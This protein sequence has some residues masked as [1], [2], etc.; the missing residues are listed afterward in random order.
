MYTYFPNKLRKNFIFIKQG[1]NAKNWKHENLVLQAYHAIQNIGLIYHWQWQHIFN[2][3]ANYSAMT[4]MIIYKDFQQ[5]KLAKY[6][7]SR[8][9]RC[10]QHRFNRDSK[11]KHIFT[12][13]SVHCPKGSV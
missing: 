8:Q 13:Y 12:E 4:H 10:E 9:N 11:G 7:T 2:Y 6:S 3:D 1:Y 5:S